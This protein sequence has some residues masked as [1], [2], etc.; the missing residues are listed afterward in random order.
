MNLSRERCSL[1]TVSVFSEYSF[2]KPVKGTLEIRASRYVGEW[3]EYATFT[4]DIDGETEF[5]LP[6]V[7]YVAGV[8]EAGG[9]GNVMLDISVIESATGYKEQTSRLFAVAESPLTV[10]LIPEGQVFKPGLPFGFL[11]VT[12]T[13]GN[14]PVNTQVELSLQ[15]IDGEYEEI[16]TEQKKVNTSKGKALVTVTPPKQAVAMIIDA[17]AEDTETSITLQASYS[18]TGNFIHVEQTSEGTPK[19]GEEIQFKV[20]STRRAVNFYYEVVS[21]DKVVFS[22]YTKNS[23]ITFDTTPLM[24]PSA[25]LPVRKSASTSRPRARRR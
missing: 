21:R 23:T 6:A 25:R 18:P 13:P 9:K 20:N 15:Y 14:E 19:I 5:E 17:R 10:Q 16:K 24:T 1:N 12:E 2:G 8:P 11:V 22:D 4:K 3:Q 7:Q